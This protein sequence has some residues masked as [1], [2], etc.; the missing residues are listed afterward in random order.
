MAKNDWQNQSFSEYLSFLSGD[1]N[2]FTRLFKRRLEDG[3]MSQDDFKKI[4]TKTGFGNQQINRLRKKYLSEFGISNSG[5][6]SNNDSSTLPGPTGGGPGSVP[7][8]TGSGSVFDDYRPLGVGGGSNNNNSN[9][10][11]S[12]FSDYR[13]LGV[14]NGSYDVDNSIPTYVAAPPSRP[15]SPDR[16]T[17]EPAFDAEEFTRRLQEALNAQNETNLATI[18]RLT[19][20]YEGRIEDLT[21]SFGNQI[22]GLQSRL[23][24]QSKAYQ[25]QI[26]SLQDTLAGN[27]SQLNQYASQISSLG[28]QLREAERNA[29]QVK[30][31]DTTYIG[32]NTAKGVRF[33]RSENMRRGAFALGT[34]QLNRGYLNNQLSINNVNL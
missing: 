3:Y 15:S 24:D 23:S 12:V 27:Q 28:N 4:Q 19:S 9:N 10:N 25:N 30:V 17:P 34:G 7:G 11:N 22:T 31:T 1:G 32:D 18:G 2:D 29:R 8:P 13:P 20:G 33:N 16:F 5:G 26:T 6:S 21:T 14:N